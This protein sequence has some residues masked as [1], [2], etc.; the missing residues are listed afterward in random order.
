MA[1]NHLNNYSFL[2]NEEAGDYPPFG[3]GII[4]NSKEF[5]SLQK[6][7]PFDI[8]YLVNR[9]FNRVEGRIAFQHSGNTVTSIV[10]G[11]FGSLETKGKLSYELI[12]NFILFITGYYREKQV[13][14]VMIRHYAN[15]Y[16]PVNGPVIALTLSHAGFRL[17]SHDINHHLPVTGKLFEEVINKMEHRKLKKC[18]DLNLTLHRGGGE[19]IRDKYSE[20]ISFRENKNIP[21]SISGDNLKTSFDMFPDKYF[22]FYANDESG[23]LIAGSVMIRILPGIL[24]YFT[25]ATNPLLKSVSPM[26]FLLKSIYEFAKERNIGIIDLGVSSL[27]NR[28]QKGLIKFK[29]HIGGIPSSRFTFQFDL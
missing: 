29:E 10:K 28:P 15:I 6:E 27:L 12:Y 5:L 17:I 23:R 11:T 25:P 14:S 3:E 24:Y 19:E 16:N 9:K 8:F 26:V 21:L 13:K 2:V 7:Y 20:M 4:F 18:I 22:L 1:E